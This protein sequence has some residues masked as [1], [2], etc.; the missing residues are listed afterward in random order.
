MKK[1]KKLLN[2]LEKYYTGITHNI[3]ML[4]LCFKKTILKKDYKYLLKQIKR[5]FPKLRKLKNNKSD[6]AIKIYNDDILAKLRIKLVFYVL[7]RKASLF[8]TGK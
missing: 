2:K 1:Y 8:L 5:I 7:K 4:R 3:S 6:Y